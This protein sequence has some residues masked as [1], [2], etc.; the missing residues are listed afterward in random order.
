[1]VQ[2]QAGLDDVIEW[3]LRV[4]C[5]GG[6]AVALLENRPMHGIFRV[7]EKSA[8]ADGLAVE[9]AVVA[10][11]D[12]LGHQTVKRGTDIAGGF[13]GVDDKGGRGVGLSKHTQTS[14][15]GDNWSDGISHSNCSTQR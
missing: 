8:V 15:D 3:L 11:I 1:D 4:K 6:S 13:G 9:T 12:F 14:D 5:D 10:V 7:V 2:A